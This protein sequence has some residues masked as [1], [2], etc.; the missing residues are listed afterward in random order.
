MRHSILV[1]CAL[2]AGTTL[3]CE[4]IK[5]A[6]DKRRNANKPPA[7]RIATSDTTKKP[8][9]ATPVPGA[10]P[11][12]KAPPV[13]GTA[14]APTT[15]PKTAAPPSTPAAPPP[16]R[17]LVEN[18]PY[19]SSDTGTIAPG[20]GVKDVEAVWGSPAALRRAGTF[21]YLHYP[22]GCERTC[23]TD[24]VVILQNDQVVDVILRWR[25]HRYS[26]ESSS[27]PGRTPERTLP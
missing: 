15:A 25:G 22:N 11:G 13:T 8:L 18:E 27:P 14:P 6:M 5:Q 10:Q 17:P 9:P 4:R 20:M 24:D 23:G 12:A 19:N 7:A 21:T 16:S 1:V 3:G 2:L 26:G